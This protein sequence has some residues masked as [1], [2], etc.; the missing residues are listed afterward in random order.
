MAKYDIVPA[1][2][3]YPLV[4]PSSTVQSIATV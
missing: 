1:L 2:V 4:Y 3:S